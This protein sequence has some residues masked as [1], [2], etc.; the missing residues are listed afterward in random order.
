MSLTR[1]RC[2]IFRLAG[3]HPFLHSIVG[4][5]TW[6]KGAAVAG[7]THTVGAGGR[8]IGVDVGEGH[9]EVGKRRRICVEVGEALAISRILANCLTLFLNQTDWLQCNDKKRKLDTFV[10]TLVIPWLISASQV[11]SGT[12]QSSPL[13]K[14]T[15]TK[16]RDTATAAQLWS[17]ILNI[18]NRGSPFWSIPCS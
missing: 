12:K 11:V 2:R 15:I 18:C 17:N 16:I 6:A 13:T 8:N 5:L 7:S 10:A 9:T 14:L 3:F 1:H 4:R